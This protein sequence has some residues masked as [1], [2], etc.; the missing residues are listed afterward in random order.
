M[1]RLTVQGSVPV[2]LEPMLHFVDP[3]C[4]REKWIKVLF[5]LAEEYGEEARDLAVRWSRGD[6]WRGSQS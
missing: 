2:P 3:W 1:R 5:A 4:D 6:L